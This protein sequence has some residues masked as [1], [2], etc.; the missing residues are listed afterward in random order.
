[1]ISL[2]SY[3]NIRIYIRNTL[4]NNNNNLRLIK[5]KKTQ[6]KN[7]ILSTQPGLKRKCLIFFF[8]FNLASFYDRRPPLRPA[9]PVLLPEEPKLRILLQVEVSFL[10]WKYLLSVPPPSHKFGTLDLFPFWLTMRD[11][12]GWQHLAMWKKNEKKREFRSQRNFYFIFLHKENVY[13]GEEA[14]DAEL[15][16]AGNVGAT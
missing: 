14:S 6:M 12:I 4:K 16:D 8:F 15:S 1:M 5:K 9:A 7:Q 3:I 2:L 10:S 13:K 11:T